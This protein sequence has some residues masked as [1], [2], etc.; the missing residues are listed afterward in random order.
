MP[1][2]TK[3][4]AKNLDF[5]SLQ[6]ITGRDVFPSWF[7]TWFTGGLNYQIEHHLFPSLPRHHFHRVQPIVQ[8]LC[9]KY[10]VKYH[11]TSFYTGTKEVLD[12]LND[13]SKLS[14]KLWD[15]GERAQ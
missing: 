11:R 1:V 13:I 4:E 9:E 5:Y 2:V 15:I 6:V 7:V 3:E 14:Q 10:Q 8:N 12:R